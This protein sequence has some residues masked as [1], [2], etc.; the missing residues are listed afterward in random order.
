MSKAATARFRL[1]SLTGDSR[2]RGVA[3]RVRTSRLSAIRVRT[4]QDFLESDASEQEN[5]TDHAQPQ[6]KH[7]QFSIG[8][9]REE[10]LAR[11][12]VRREEFCG[13]LYVKK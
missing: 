1:T 4:L 2:W 12:P 13:F 3:S 9:L 6:R 5:F 10:G 7:A 11:V 8:Y